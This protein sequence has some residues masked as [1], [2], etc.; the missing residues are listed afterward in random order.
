M[1][2]SL[3]WPVTLFTCQFSKPADFLSLLHQF[4]KP[5]SLKLPMWLCNW[6]Y[7]YSCFDKGCPTKQKNRTR[8]NIPIG[9][10]GGKSEV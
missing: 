1:D 4:S 6:E 5:A 7:R 10:M 8:Q 9:I 3:A 2:L